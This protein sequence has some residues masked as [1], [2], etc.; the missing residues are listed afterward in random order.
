MDDK[1]LI[2]LVEKFGSSQLAE[3]ELNDGS[4]HLVLRKES[5]IRTAL[6]GVSIGG[7]AAEAHQAASDTGHSAAPSQAHKADHAVHLGLPVNAGS[8]AAT[9]E[10]ITSPIVATFYRAASPDTPPFVE[11]GSKVK[12]GQTLCI[13]E[14]MKMMNH[15]EAEFD[16]EILSVK[17]ENGSL[18]EYG[19]ALFEVK[20]L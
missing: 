13:L 7:A 9:G 11:V 1:T 5:A 2:T 12:A 15:L 4:M 3:L 20:R 17:A 16:C 18:V 8:P 10:I 6:D 14:A 19:Q